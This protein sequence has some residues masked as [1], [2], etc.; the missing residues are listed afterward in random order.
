MSVKFETIYYSVNEGNIP[1]KFFENKMLLWEM[2]CIAFPTVHFQ[3]TAF[4]LATMHSDGTKCPLPTQASKRDLY[5]ELPD[6]Q[7]LRS[8]KCFTCWRWGPRPQ[9]CKHPHSRTAGAQYKKP[10]SKAGFKTKKPSGVSRSARLRAQT[11][12]LTGPWSNF[13]SERCL[14]YLRFSI[15]FSSPITSLQRGSTL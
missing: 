5:F 14:S 10:A 4:L 2:L 12:S 3:C 11:V 9:L 6:H 7:M 8:H 13:P 15:R 1:T